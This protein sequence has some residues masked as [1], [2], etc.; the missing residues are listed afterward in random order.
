MT[1]HGRIAVLALGALALVLPASASAKVETKHHLEMYKQEQHITLPEYDTNTYTLS[2]PGSDLAADGMW[3]IDEVGPYN[4]QLA[5]DD[6]SPWTVGT[7]VSVIAAWPSASDTYTFT[8][9]NNTSEDAQM[10]IWVTCLGD[11]TAPDTHQNDLVAGP[12]T[13]VD[14]DYTGSGQSVQPNATA[15]SCASGEFFITPGFKVNTGQ[16]YLFASTPGVNLRDWT[17]GFY[18]ELPG[19]SLTVYGRCLEDFTDYAPLPQHH[20]HKIYAYLKTTAQHFNRGNG[21]WEHQIHC[22]DHQ[23]GLV[24]GFHLGNGFGWNNYTWYWLGMDPRIKSRSYHTLGTGN[25]GS[26]YLVCFNDRT[27]RPFYT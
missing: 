13:S 8:F 5:D 27:S 22:G 12:I 26:Y 11:K 21:T 17:Y 14:Y 10:K 9:R 25:G 1:F 7:G 2:C 6:E 24:G 15:T 18:V 20:R 19:T 3:R 16:A 23:K 4:A